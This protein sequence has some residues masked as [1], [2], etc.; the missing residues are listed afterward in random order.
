MN[1]FIDPNK[2]MY[3]NLAIQ[4]LLSIKE[5][6]QMTW[7]QVS[8]ALCQILKRDEQSKKFRS[9]IEKLQ[10]KKNQLLNKNLDKNLWGWLDKKGNTFYAKMA[11][12]EADAFEMA[13][14]EGVKGEELDKLRF[15]VHP[16]LA[17][18]GLVRI[19]VSQAFSGSVG[20][21]IFGQSVTP[22]QMEIIKIY[23]EETD[24]F[25]WDSPWNHGNSFNSFVRHVNLLKQD[26]GKVTADVTESL[27]EEEKDY[28]EIP[29]SNSDKKA[30]VDIDD[31][32][33]L[34]QYSWYLKK[35]NRTGL[36]YVASGKRVEGKVQTIRMHRL[37][38][39]A[40]PDMDA[41]HKDLNPLNNRKNN[42]EL[43]PKE[44]HRG[45]PGQPKQHHPMEESVNESTMTEFARDELKK[46]GLFDKDS[47]YDGMIGE[48]VMEL[49]NK[50]AEQGHSG[51]SAGLTTSIFNKLAEYK[52]LS[53]LTDDPNEWMKISDSDY[54]CAEE[55]KNVSLWQSKRCPSCFS[56]D[57]GKT[58]YDIDDEG[59]KQVDEKGC[60]WNVRPESYGRKTTIYKS[61]CV[62]EQ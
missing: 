17:K 25:Y 41:H 54:G 11:T 56:N 36:W 38:V 31:L 27:N 50:F 13:K 35:D 6:M 24:N 18:K 51:F 28:T 42:L 9:L 39:N 26:K 3:Q 62:N 60:V 37:V 5:N 55:Y 19:V 46:A 4:E 20:I 44:E 52:P 7:E 2:L 57:G 58:Y 23:N 53:P 8:L 15:N 33:K 22:E 45:H 49:I 48:A 21:E 30:I 10:V 14:K 40:P 43:I 32:P 12:H 47:D 16:W 61:K 59:H 1:N 29:L 34:L